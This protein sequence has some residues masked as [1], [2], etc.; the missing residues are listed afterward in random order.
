MQAWE[1]KFDSLALSRGKSIWEDRKV[2]EIKKQDG[3]VTAAVMGIP[4]YEVSFVMTEGVPMRLKCQCPKYRRGSNCEH[5]AAVLYALHENA[6]PAGASDAKKEAMQKEAEK[7]AAIRKAAIIEAA[8]KRAIEE[9]AEKKQAAQEE[10]AREQHRQE[11]ARRIAQREA[12]KKAKKAERKK[13]RQE[14]ELAENARRQ[15]AQRRQ[16]EQM[17][18]TDAEQ[19]YSYFQYDRLKEELKI[20]EATLAEGRTLFYKGKFTLDNVHSGFLSEGAGEMVV[21]VRGSGKERNAEFSIRI[22]HGRD[23]YFSVNCECP[24]CRKNFSWYYRDYNCPYVAGLLMAGENY[25][26]QHN[27]GE[28]TNRLGSNILYGYRTSHAKSIIAENAEQQQI[29]LEPRLQRSGEDLRLSFRV[30]EGKLFVVKDLFEFCRLVKNSETGVYGNNTELN[31]RIDHFTQRSKEWYSL[32]SKAVKEEEELQYRILDEIGSTVKKSKCSSIKLYGWRLDQFYEMLKEQEVS[33]EDKTLEGKQKCMLTAREAEPKVKMRIDKLTL[34]EKSSSRGRKSSQAVFHGISVTCEMPVFFQGMDTSYYVE[35]DALYKA[36]A[37]AISAIAPLESRALNGHISFQVG[38]RSL[39]EFYYEMLPLISAYVEIE[40]SDAASEIHYYLSPEAQFVFCLDAEQNNMTCRLLARYGEE[41]AEVLDVLQE[42]NGM[43]LAPYRMKNKESEILYLT[44]RLF[45]AID[46]EQRV[47]HCDQDEELM[48]QILDHGVGDLMELGEV[49]CTK[50]FRNMNVMRRVKMSVGVSLSNGLLDLNIAT[51]DISREELLEILK[52]Y[53]ANKRFYRLKNGDFLNMEDDSVRLLKEMMETLHLSPREFVKGKMHLP[54]Y[55]TLYL[56]K[57]LE[58]NETVYSNRDSHF[59]EMVKNFKTVSDADYEEPGELSQIMRGYQKNGFKWLKTL[60]SYGF[61]GI[62]AD[63]MGLGKTLQM[64]AV[65]LSNHENGEK[66]ASLV[67]SPASLVYNW[68][69]EFHKFAPD[70]RVLAV[71][72]TQEVRQEKL[73]SW[74]DYDVLLTSYDLLKRD[75]AFYEDMQF[76]YQVIDEAQYIKNHTTA[77]AKAV[78][79]IKSRV[80]FALTGTPIENRLSE[81]WSI[82]DYLMPGFLY[83]YD[84]FRK[85]ME[86]PIVKNG[87]EETLKRLQKMTSPFI[88][89]RL[90]RDVLKDLPDKLEEIRYVQLEETQQRTYD[91]QVVQM[92]NQL[93]GQ[94]GEEFNRNKLKIFAELTRLRQICC[95]PSLCFSN[96]V[97]ESAKREACLELIQSAI[98]GGHKVLLFSQFTS[99]LDILQQELEKLGIAYYVI[100]GSTP[101]EKRLSLVKSFNEDQV[102]LF[103]VSLKAGGVGLNLTGADVVIHYDPWWNQAVQEQATDRAHRIGQTKNVTVYKLIARHTVEEKIQKL[104]ETKKDLADSIVN[105]QTGQ[106]NTLSKEEFLELLM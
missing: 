84:V 99:M 95:D 9:E 14:A 76:Q 87:E 56:D 77:A 4:R 8:R 6:A 106:F 28:A 22:L 37:D 51:Q 58:E 17:Q 39:T 16:E 91:A 50:R 103:L 88:L 98:D 90:K 15:E 72:G 101:K 59:R 96:Y 13:R 68:M 7:L 12:E 86:S 18:P 25:V 53:R 47:L 32:L 61:G 60:E 2:E 30:G 38:R 31:H 42:R 89:R 81:L 5:M 20:T 79:V 102:P 57:L 97:G 19:E 48:F 92:Q 80:K 82:F 65:I 52:G 73:R 27:L 46:W 104:Q 29:T 26:R 10:A 74:Q 67:V 23:K 69:E 21:D 100:T 55:R 94:S 43:V 40:E 45:P 83:G 36:G 71:T 41:E 105:A 3:H 75:I 49:Q 35:K 64:I 1:S 63:D 70:L 33:Y 85:E 78:K 34:E 44:R 24:R 62:L 11:V 93:N 66:G 54:V